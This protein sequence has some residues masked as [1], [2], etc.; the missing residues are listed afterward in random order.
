MLIDKFTEDNI[1]S[2]HQEGIFYKRTSTK[3][4]NLYAEVRAYVCTFFWEKYL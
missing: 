4:T 1:K 2:L 3:A